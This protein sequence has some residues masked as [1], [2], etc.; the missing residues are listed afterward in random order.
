VGLDMA[1]SSRIIDASS[2]VDDIVA[3]LKQLEDAARGGALVLGTGTGL[4]STIEAVS[5]WTR[6]LGARG[7]VLV[8]ASSLFHRRSG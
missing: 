4:A 3:N 2:S 5:G 7:I 8:P 6:D 1:R